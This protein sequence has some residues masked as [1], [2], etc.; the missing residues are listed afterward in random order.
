MAKSPKITIILQELALPH[1]IILIPLSED[2]EVD[3]V[4]LNP[5]DGFQP[6]TIPTQTLHFGNLE[7]SWST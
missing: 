4:K 6:F 1:E 3:Y 7:P 2:T 5:M